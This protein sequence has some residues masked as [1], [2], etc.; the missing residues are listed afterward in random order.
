MLEAARII[1]STD[2]TR[3]ANV[4]RKEKTSTVHS[5]A[6]NA[7]LGLYT[8]LQHQTGKNTVIGQ[9]PRAP[10]KPKMALKKGSSTARKVTRQT[11]ER[12]SE[13]V[14]MGPRSGASKNH[15]HN[16]PYRTRYPS[17]T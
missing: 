5:K 10:T 12:A 14:S 8:F 13:R 15:N 9:K 11:G 7:G 4:T 2:A 6:L 1:C 3:T 17:R 16:P